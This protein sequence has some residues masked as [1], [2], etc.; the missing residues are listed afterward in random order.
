M[1]KTLVLLALAMI[2]FTTFA[3]KFEPSRPVRII[4]PFPPGT[5]PDVIARKVAESLSS[6]WSKPVVVDNRPGGSGNIA[7]T[8]FL[9]EPADGHTLILADT[10]IMVFNPILIN[11]YTN[12][13]SLETILPLYSGAMILFSSSNVKNIDELK[14]QLNVK[15]FYGSWGVGSL[16]HFAGFEFGKLIGKQSDHIAY[17]EYSQWF[18]DVG[19]QDVTFGFAG[20]GSSKAMV[21]QGRIHYLAIADTARHPNYPNVP[22]VQELT[23]KPLSVVGM[24]TLCINKNTPMSI[25]SDISFSLK[26]A[27]LSHNVQTAI[28]DNDYQSITHMSNKE[29]DNAVQKYRIKNQSSI[30]QLNN[31]N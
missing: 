12:I 6:D 1:K 11:Q 29:F 17:K 8:A 15:N 28:A 31:I 3:D 5:G 18:I 20:I 22:T 13:D 26:K 7:L 2:S 10:G 16:G 27:A 25:K 19:N 9:K 14:S 4:V 21:Q 23:G 30:K 24:L